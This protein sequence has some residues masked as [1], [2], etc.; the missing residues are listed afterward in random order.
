M[1]KKKASA[2]LL[3]RAFASEPGIG[4]KSVAKTTFTD[5]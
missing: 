3:G 2:K 4:Q 5:R 1:L